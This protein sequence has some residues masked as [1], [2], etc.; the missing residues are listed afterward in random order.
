MG[1]QQTWEVLGK[2]AGVA[3]YAVQFIKFYMQIPDFL[4]T[5]LLQLFSK[6]Q[7]EEMRY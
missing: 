5:V 2:A 4:S 1:V 6:P 7:T 3:G